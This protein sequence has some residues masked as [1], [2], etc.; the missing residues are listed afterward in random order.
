MM[1]DLILKC[2]HC[3]KELLGDVYRVDQGSFGEKSIGHFL[4]EFKFWRRIGYFCS[5]KC[6]LE[7][8]KRR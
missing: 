5:I 8:L 4:E 7:K 3:G 1:A 6:L 2:A